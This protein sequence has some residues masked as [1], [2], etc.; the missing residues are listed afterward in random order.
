MP[1]YTFEVKAAVSVHA[2]DEED[3]RQKMVQCAMEEDEDVLYGKELYVYLNPF[4]DVDPDC[5]DVEPD[6]M[7]EED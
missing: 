5:I 6:A 7:D 3:A 1:T 2:D 4:P